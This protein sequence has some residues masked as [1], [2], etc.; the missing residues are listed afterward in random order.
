MKTSAPF[1]GSQEACPVQ[2]ATCGQV[3]LTVVGGTVSEGPEGMG[4]MSVKNMR[5]RNEREMR[6]QIR[7]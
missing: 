4:G 7:I 1:Q 2:T 5:I 6:G 3:L